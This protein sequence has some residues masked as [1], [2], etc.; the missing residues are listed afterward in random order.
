MLWWWTLEHREDGDLTG[1]F[2]RDIAQACDWQGNPAILKKALLKSGFLDK[3]MHVHDW[4]AYAGRLLRER[5]RGRDRRSSADA[6]AVNPKPT[7]RN[8]TKRNG[9]RQNPDIFSKDDKKR[10]LARICEVRKYGLE[11]LAAAV[12]L[13]EFK[14]V[15]N[16]NKPKDPMAYVMGI[17]KK[18]EMPHVA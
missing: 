15:C 14:M 13:E 8:E 6:S 11:S 16:Q 5:D 10:L 4:Y 12:A 17:L 18:E 9:E 7:K 2:D 3:D 1:L